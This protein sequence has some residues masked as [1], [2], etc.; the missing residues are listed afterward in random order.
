MILFFA[1]LAVAIAASPIEAPAPPRDG[2]HIV[3]CAV[4]RFCLWSD[5]RW[6]SVDERPARPRSR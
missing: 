6:R 5:G 4:A 2:A 1:G 3:T